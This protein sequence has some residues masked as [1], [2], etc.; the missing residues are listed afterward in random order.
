MEAREVFR[1]VFAGLAPQCEGWIRATAEGQE[2]TKVDK[3]GNM[4]KL[5]VGSDP[6]K[7]ADLLLRLAE[8]HIPKL[9]RTEITGADGDKL[10]V[11]VNISG[12]REKEQSPPEPKKAF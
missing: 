7:A 12:V 3:A 9:G 11:T 8:F 10:T 1:L 4:V 5:R 2:I 6:G